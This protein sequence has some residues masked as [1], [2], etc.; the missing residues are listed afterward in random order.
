M[1]PALDARLGSIAATVA[2]VV[3]EYAAARHIWPHCVMLARKRD[4]GCC[5]PNRR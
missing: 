4:S 1:R 2:I 3:L 5:G